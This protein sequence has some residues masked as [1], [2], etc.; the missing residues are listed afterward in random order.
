MLIPTAYQKLPSKEGCFNNQILFGGTTSQM[1]GAAAQLSNCKFLG[2]AHYHVGQTILPAIGGSI[3]YAVD[4]SNATK[5]ARTYNFLYQSTHLSSQL[6][7][8]VQYVASHFIATTV[9]V[10]M[11]LRATASNSYTGTILDYGV[12]FEEG[13]D[14]THSGEIGVA[15]TGT[16]IISQPSN[17]N[18]EPPRTLYVPTA[19]R[20][21][22][23]NVV[24]SSTQALPITVHIYDLLIPSVTP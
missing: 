18:P 20:G 23:L 17:T 1:S 11:K 7:L 16:E 10:E 8:L 3:S 13:V 6:V 2:Q 24:I 22:L 19:N 15:F 12:K 4:P 9:S 21:E 14:L 5:I